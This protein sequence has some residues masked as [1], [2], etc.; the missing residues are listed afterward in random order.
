METKEF[1]WNARTQPLHWC[2][3]PHFGSLNS[4]SFFFHFFLQQSFSLFF[5]FSLLRSAP[6]RQVVL[7]CV[8]ALDWLKKEKRKRLVL[9]V[10][11]GILTNIHKHK[12]IRLYFF[13]FL[14][15]LT[16]ILSHLL[17]FV[18]RTFQ[19]KKGNT[20]RNAAW[21]RCP[22]SLLWWWGTDWI[23]IFFFS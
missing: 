12:C 5:F 13:N 19:N 20:H 4:L 11:H 18:T 23:Y 9:L 14:I 22:T 17:H 3:F 21:K 2:V 1:Y 6:V 16:R 7:H 10:L 15:L 8:N